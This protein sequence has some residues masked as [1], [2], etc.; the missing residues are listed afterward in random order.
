MP[1]S[2][3][4]RNMAW[5]FG[6]QSSDL[7]MPRKYRW[8][9]KIED[10]SA[11]GINALPPQKGSRPSFSFKEMEAQ[12]L[13]ETVY[14]PQKPEWKPITLTLYEPVGQTSGGHP[15]FEWLKRTYDPQ[16]DS[17]WTPSVA[18]GG[19]GLKIP[20]CT[21]EMFDGCG[22]VIETW[23]FE[24]VYPQAIDFGDLDMGSSEVTTCD[25]TIRYDRAYIE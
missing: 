17:K 24:A 15:V 1:S 22:E 21:L 19:K 23:I 18:S 5:D 8:L 6:L 9:F 10:V 25:V 14:F 11:E 7:C 3:S 12:H 4:G 16:A 2:G 13:T 20:K